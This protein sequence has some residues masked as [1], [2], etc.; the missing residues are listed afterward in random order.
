MEQSVASLTAETGVV[1]S[2]L[3][4]SHTFMKID[5]KIISTVIL[6]LLPIH[7]GLLSVASESMCTKYWLVKLAQEK[8]WLDELTVP[9]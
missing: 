1:R 4:R 7:E 3:A 2:I 9:T 6:F 5:H 8:V